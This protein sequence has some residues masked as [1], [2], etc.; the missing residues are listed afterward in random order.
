MWGLGWKGR[1]QYSDMIVSF[2]DVSIAE[3][4]TQSIGNRYVSV[5]V[6]PLCHLDELDAAELRVGVS[7]DGDAAGVD[8][9]LELA[10]GLVGQE[11]NQ[12][13]A[14]FILVG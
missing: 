12:V 11:R 1:K 9:V 2:V 8:V 4:V 14:R 3:Y 5:Y 10:I 13:S 7:G 6:Y